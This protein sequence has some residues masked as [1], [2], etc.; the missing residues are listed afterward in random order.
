MK[1]REFIA[2]SCLAG[3]APAG[4]AVAAGSANPSGKEYYELRLYHLEAGAKARQFEEFLADAAIPALN[5]IGIKPVG[6][7]KSMEG[8]DPN[9][10]VLMPHQSPESFLTLTEQLAADAVFV[11]A[12]MAVLEAPKSDPAYQ[13]FESSLMV[14]FDGHPKVAVPSSKDSRILQLRIYESHNDE[15]AKKKIEMF[16]DGGEIEIFLRTG[17]NPVFFGES[18]IGSKLP[19]L[20]YML[21]FDDEKALDKGWKAF[22]ADPGWN[23]LKKDPQYKDTVSN[24][25]NLLLRPAAGSQI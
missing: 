16:N 11:E 5:R 17:L 23:V 9:L 22:R 24:I 21:G 19:N 18:L 13:R 15:R 12:A 4:A 2:A 14:A 1:R 8:D 20:T 25:T 6:A 3:L 7:F 10:W